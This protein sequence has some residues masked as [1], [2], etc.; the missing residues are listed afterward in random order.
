MT[1]TVHALTLVK[2]PWCIM[3]QALSTLNTKT[4]GYSTLRDIIVT[5][6]L[7][8]PLGKRQDLYTVVI[9]FVRKKQTEYLRYKQQNQK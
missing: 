4:Q 8:H 9:I 7:F 3:L 5:F 6:K 1:D 2:T